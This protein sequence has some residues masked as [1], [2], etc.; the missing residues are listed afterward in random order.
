MDRRDAA[1]GAGISW[2]SEHA[3]PTVT[4]SSDGVPRVLVM[5]GHN[6]QVRFEPGA[7][8]KLRAHRFEE[9]GDPHQGWKGPRLFRLLR[10]ASHDERPAI[11][12]ID[13]LDAAFDE[14]LPP[15]IEAVTAQGGEV[16]LMTYLVPGAPPAELPP[17]EAAL[18]EDV[19]AA[20]S[21]VNAVIR[22]QAT[23]RRL[24]LIDLEAMVPVGDSWNTTQWLDHIHPS[25]VLTRD[26][27][28]SIESTLIPQESP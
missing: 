11:A 23:R 15:L 5:L 2:M 22:S 25:E 6:D 14:H 3:V 13:V 26:M 19:Q 18:L 4:A 16:V 7:G 24:G 1:P 21:T 20:Q 17:D 27:A 8:R 12:G 9:L 10:W 28:E